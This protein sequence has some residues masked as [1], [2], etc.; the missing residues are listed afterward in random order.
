MTD[1]KIL[2]LCAHNQ[3]RSTTAEGLLTGEKGYQVKSRALWR[4]MPREVTIEDGEWA[5]E[6]YVMMP[7]MKKVAKKSGL[8]EQKL[9]ALRIPDMFM[10]CELPLLLELKQQLAGWGIHVKKDM[11][12]AERDCENVMVRKGIYGKAESGGWYGLYY[13][14]WHLEQGESKKKGLRDF[15][16]A[17]V[18]KWAA[19][20]EKWAKKGQG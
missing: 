9:K 3:S 16:D 15:E 17:A 20:I 13:P 19:G 14:F 4:G 18:A 2:F 11:A 12:Q 7:G 8:P 10:A 6:I 5:D 1:K